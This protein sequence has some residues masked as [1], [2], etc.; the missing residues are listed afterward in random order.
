MES[1]SQSHENSTATLRPPHGLSPVKT[2]EAE[3]VHIVVG[4]LGYS[5]GSEMCSADWDTHR[6]LQ[7]RAPNA[8]ESAQTGGIAAY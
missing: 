6:V 7:H 4:G 8:V 3:S 2:L 1:I 5:H